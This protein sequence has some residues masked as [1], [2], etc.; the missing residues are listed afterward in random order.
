MMSKI[1][2]NSIRAPAPR[3]FC[4]APV[5][6]VQQRG[7]NAFDGFFKVFAFQSGIVEECQRL[8]ADASDL[9]PQ[10]GAAAEA[11]KALRDSSAE[12]LGVML[13]GWPIDK[14]SDDELRQAYVGFGKHV[15]SVVDQS[16]DLGNNA[17][18]D[19]HARPGEHRGSRSQ[20]AMPLHTDAAGCEI[21]HE[22]NALLCVQPSVGDGQTP[23]VSAE[24]IY[25]DLRESNPRALDIVTKGFFYRHPGGN[26]VMPFT[27][28][29]VPALRFS[30][31][32]VETVFAEKYVDKERLTEEE[33][34]AMNAFIQAA[35]NCR[36]QVDVNWCRGD[37]AFWHNRRSLH[38]RRHFTDPARRLLR[39]WVTTEDTQ[40]GDLATLTA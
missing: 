5:E 25:E 31:G 21:H 11:V 34:V 40:L 4:T 30:E 33:L 14:L 6:T 2:F 19:V 27:E 7:L 16:R 38:G 8:A 36:R 35:K 3:L 28:E 26:D 29:R 23:F 9:G 12:A 15:G 22:F 39:L 13:T 24:E 32:R 18:N 17:I 10:L 37:A 1:A 20:C